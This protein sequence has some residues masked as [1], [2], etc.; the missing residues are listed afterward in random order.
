MPAWVVP[1][2]IAAGGAIVNMVTNWRDRK[3]NENYVRDQ[4]AYNS[5]KSQ[6]LRFQQAGLNPHLIYGQGNPGNQSTT[7]TAPE[8][9]AGTDI[10]QSYNQSSIQQ[11]QVAAN[12]AGIERTKALTE[13]AKLQSE[14]LAR[15]PYLNNEAYSAIIDSL[16]TTADLKKKDASLKQLEIWYGEA[17]RGT[18]ASKMFKEVELL[19][20]RFK[21]GEADLKIKA[22]ILNSVQFKNAILEVQKKFLAD[23]DVGPNQILQFIFLLL[24]KS[25]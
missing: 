10:A 21:L 19:E 8:S 11:S 13:V 5:P 3:I 7:L 24:N 4:N 12:T 23:G 9:R 22:E 25:L 6:M 16:V 2:A 15:N 20:Q 1:A 17:T 18:S 14:V